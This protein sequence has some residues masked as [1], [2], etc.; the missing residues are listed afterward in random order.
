M[1][2]RI[3]SVDALYSEFKDI[4]VKTRDLVTERGLP[5]VLYETLRTS[6]RQDQLQ[7]A[8]ASNASGLNSPHQWGCAADWILDVKS[9]YWAANGCTPLLIP[10]ARVV[11]RISSKT[12]DAGAP[13]DEGVELEDGTPILKRPGILDVWK[14]LG[15]CIKEACG[16]DPDRPAP[17]V[18]GGDWYERGASPPTHFMGWDAGHTQHA[19]WR[20]IAAKLKTPPTFTPL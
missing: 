2:K 11:P 16:L 8:G 18:W 19:E 9:V 5:F 15:R 3:E 6:D 10:A 4:A 13:W 12:A 7:A 17:Q 14:G 20:A 1:S